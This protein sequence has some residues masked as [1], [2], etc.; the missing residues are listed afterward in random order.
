MYSRF[1][2]RHSPA[3]RTFSCLRSDHARLTVAVRGCIVSALPP[4]PPPPPTLLGESRDRGGTLTALVGSLLPIWPRRF[5]GKQ[6]GGETKGRVAG[7][8]FVLHRS[9]LQR[10]LSIQSG[11]FRAS[12]E[13]ELYRLGSV[14]CL[15]LKM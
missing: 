3:P 6:G 14:L 12:F 15:T 4:P 13:M 11:S 8:A 10:A 1:L 9:T 2:Q 5:F 7:G